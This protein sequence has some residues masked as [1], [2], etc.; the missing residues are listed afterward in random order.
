MRKDGYG[1][2]ALGI[3]LALVFLT[4]CGEA[5]M[6]GPGALPLSSTMTAQGKG[7][8]RM[9]QEAKSEDLIY[10][11]GDGCGGV[12]ILSYPDG[13][14]VGNISDS[15]VTG[16]DCSDSDGNVFVTS[17]TQVLE[18]AHGGS[19]PIATLSLPGTQAQA[20]G[21]DST[22]GNL[23]VVFSG[24]GANVAIFKNASG[25]PALYESYAT[26]FYCGYDKSG[27]LFVSVLNNHSPGLAELAKG[28]STVTV[29][30]VAG[31]LGAEG[32]VQW[33]GSYLTY[34]GRDSRHVKVSRLQISGSTAV[35]AGVTQIRRPVNAN[36]TW[37]TSNR[38]IVSYSTKASQIN[39][40]GLW[41]YPKSGKAVTKFG[42]FGTALERI[43]GVTLSKG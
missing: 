39:R 43:T 16:G 30:S 34:E 21:V 22:T 27:N 29:L 3:G 18:F 25:T 4:G 7:P 8:S 20:C 28:S 26:P 32:Q 24:S 6:A 14:M 13:K 35:V 19:S 5:Q 42:T 11:E 9:L 10:A 1:G 36:Q 41:K 15:D 33:D 17:N 38:V 23:A 2:R 31:D 37:I 40:I 12:C